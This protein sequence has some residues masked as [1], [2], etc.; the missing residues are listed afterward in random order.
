MWIPGT[1]MA[2][3]CDII[4]ETQDS[5]SLTW[6]LILLVKLEPLCTTQWCESFL[7]LQLLPWTFVLVKPYSFLRFPFKHFFLRKNLH[8][9]PPQSDSNQRTVFAVS[10]SN[11]CFYNSICIGGFKSRIPSF[12]IR[13]DKESLRGQRL[14]LLSFLFFI[15][16]EPQYKQ[17][18]EEFWHIIGT[19]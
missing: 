7:C 19:W 9:L 3:L 4:Q 13:L 8:D 5:N 14:F 1:R 10:R 6:C 15:F 16:F 2:Q 18:W 17:C 12:P 11:L